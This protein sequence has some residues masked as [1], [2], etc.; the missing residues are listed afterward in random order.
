[1]FQKGIE[2]ATTVLVGTEASGNGTKPCQIDS[3]NSHNTGAAD[4]P[5]SGSYPPH[6]SSGSLPAA[7]LNM[8]PKPIP[9]ILKPIPKIVA[10][11]HTA[12]LL[13]R[14]VGVI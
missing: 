4:L 7:R 11:P 9:K 8:A 2:H 13:T 12:P 6:R 14:T 1:M 5:S 3:K 10:R